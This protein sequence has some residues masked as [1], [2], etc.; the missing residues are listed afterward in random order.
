M[1]NSTCRTHSLLF[2][3]RTLHAS[4]DP[5]QLTA[6]GADYMHTLL[7][8]FELTVQINYLVNLTEASFTP[9]LAEAETNSPIDLAQGCFTPRL[10]SAQTEEIYQKCVLFLQK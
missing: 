8:C 9:Q 7:Q 5:V 2:C 4:D 10:A 1:K 6:E 3:G